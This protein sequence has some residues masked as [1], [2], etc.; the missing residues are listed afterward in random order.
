MVRDTAGTPV[1][2]SDVAL[3]EDGFEDVRRFARAN[4]EPGQGLGIKKQRGANAVAVAR[5]VRAEME[6]IQETLPEGMKLGVNFDSTQF[7]EESVHEIQFE[8]MLAVLLTA[9][10]CWIF[11]GSLS[12]TMNVHLMFGFSL[13]C[14]SAVP[15]SDTYLCTAA[16]CATP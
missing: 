4:G 1:Y 16:S 3:V 14:A 7:I 11:L 5:A 15:T 9:I 12:S 13:F 8:L 6:E 10:V 2:L